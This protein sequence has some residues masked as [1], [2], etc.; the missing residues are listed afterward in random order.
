VVV[1][2]EILWTPGT[3]R[4]E[5]A[6][7]TR[8]RRWLKEQ[9]GLDFPDYDALWRWSV[10]DIEAF[11]ASIW[12]CF[13]ILS[14]T[15]YS[16]VLDRRTMPGARWFEGSRVNFAE[17]LLRHEAD[18]PAAP[19]FLHL[20]EGMP[21]AS[22]SRGEL[23][24][25]VRKVATWLR[26]NGI[27][28]GDRVVSYM[29]NVPA[30]AVM[31]IATTA[32][33]AIWSSAA[34]EFGAPTVLDRFRQIEPKLLL[35]TAGYM[36][37]GKHQDRAQAV[38]DITAAL[39]SLRHLVWFDA[40]GQT[41]LPPVDAGEAVRISRWNDLL[42]GPAIARAAFRF[43]RVPYDHPLWILYSSGTTGLPKAIVHSH[44]GIL[45]EL[46]KLL[47]LHINLTPRSIV[48][49]YTTTG[50]MMWNFLVSVLLTG[51]TA[52]LYDGSPAWPEPD[53]MWKL[54]ADT[55][56]TV[57][58]GGPTYMQMTEKLGIRPGERYDLSAVE[59]LMLAGAPA[60]PEVFAWLYAA[61]SR[62]LWV[63]SSSGGTEICSG[64]VGSV[65]V[66]PVRAGEIQT[67]ML[68]MDVDSW[69][70]E[71]QPVRDTVGELVVKQPAPSMPTHFWGDTDGQRYHDSYF[72]VWPGV[73]RHGDFIKIMSHGGCIITGRSDST[74]NRHG[75]RIG[76]AEIY[77]VVE[78][79]PLVEDSLVV[80]YETGR[81]SFFMPLFVRLQP[82]QTLDDPMRRA[83]ND[84]LRSQCSPRHVPD[85]ILQ[86]DDIPYTLTGKKMEIPVRRILTGTPVEKAASPDAMK[87]PSA[88]RLF[89]ALKDEIAARAQA[90]A[91]NA[92]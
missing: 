29:P 62:D 21:I 48:A 71:G 61:V 5:A 65:P 3:A 63:A 6:G 52:V 15:P 72:S 70:D 17:H 36:F 37:G 30:T 13:G 8:Y 10:T 47:H 55:R 81:E 43:E 41:A 25:Q 67:R 92:R 4:I 35:A 51:S 45:V 60:S 57:F 26:A 32:I 44:V 66:L 75:V 64:F 80:C 90:I 79:N 76:T 87:N 91:G 1:E 68:G 46:H 33:G 82:G 22:I 83:I 89:A 73:W 2:G 59:S 38:A 9:R 74:L 12:D 78:Q 11:W 40:P 53:V 69:D 34:I 50:W 56:A 31:M 85:A 49:F 39:P 54:A 28:P 19:A 88:I 16:R 42:D 24:D 77:R 18:D 7:I 86:V 27:G 14:D 20:T 58:G 23:G 84:A